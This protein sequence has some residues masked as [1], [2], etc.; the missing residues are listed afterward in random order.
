MSRQVRIDELA[1]KRDAAAEHGKLALMMTYQ[2]AIDNLLAGMPE[3]EPR[4]DALQAIVAA[5]MAEQDVDLS[6]A[7]MPSDGAFL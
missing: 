4:A 2:L 1:R 5:K 3:N 7:K 6:Q